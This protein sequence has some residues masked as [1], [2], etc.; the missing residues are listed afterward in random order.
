MTRIALIRHGST[1]WNKEGR[2]QGSTDIPLDA[3]GIMQAQKLGLRLSDEHWDL[4]YS[5]HLS[6]ARQTGEIIA[7]QLG[8]PDFFQDE[9]LREVSGGQTEGTSEEER[10]VKWGADWRQLELGMET[11][12]AVCNRGLAFIDDL[13]EEHAGKHILIV[14]HGSFI[15]HLLR[16]LAPTLTITEHLKNTSVT[17]FNIKDNLWDCELYN[18]TKHLNEV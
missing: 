12:I 6:R 13:L 10:I 5:S 14:S 4:V 1:A 2:M 17:R 18:C 15:R 9:R 11:E 7:A 3:E 16:K 8:I